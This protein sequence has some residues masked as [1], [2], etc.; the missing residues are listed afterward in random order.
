MRAEDNERQGA[1]PALAALAVLELALSGHDIPPE[2]LAEILERMGALRERF[3]GV[4]GSAN[5]PA[6]DLSKLAWLAPRDAGELVPTRSGALSIGEGGHVFEAPEQVGKTALILTMLR[7]EFGIDPYDTAQCIPIKAPS[8][9]GRKRMDR[10]E[11]R[12]LSFP[13]L[14]KSLLV[15][16][17]MQNDTYVLHTADM[18]Q[19]CRYAAMFKPQLQLAACNGEVSCISW[20]SKQGKTLAKI[21]DAFRKSDS[22]LQAE[23]VAEGGRVEHFIKLRNNTGLHPQ[24]GE[25]LSALAILTPQ[26]KVYHWAMARV[27]NGRLQCVK[28]VRGDNGSELVKLFKTED[29]EAL[30]GR[31]KNWLHLDKSGMVETEGRM[32]IGLP[33]FLL[34][35]GL[36]FEIA[37]EVLG[38][39]KSSGIESVDREVFMGSKIQTPYWLDDVAPY[40]PAKL[41]G[42]GVGY[43]YEKTGEGT[44]TK[45]I[46]VTSVHSYAVANCCDKKG[47]LRRVR[48]AGIQCIPNKV[49]PEK[50]GAS[51][52][53]YRVD[54]VKCLLPQ[55][56]DENGEIDLLLLDGTHVKA[57][58]VS[59]AVPDR[60][61][62]RAVRA[63]LRHRGI[64]PLP[65]YYCVQAPGEMTKNYA[66]V[67]ADE[68]LPIINEVLA[69]RGKARY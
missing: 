5:K 21:K 27:L 33:A 34:K 7:D 38:N 30:R 12:L 68:A 14:G 51:A 49:I 4:V 13:R 47:L 6:I 28:G 1:Q 67:L 55:I 56:T 50:G 17:A 19:V 42:N 48:E 29:L 54:D 60:D 52:E 18:D 46:A 26:S 24:T 57:L 3:G 31:Y 59:L 37:M 32:L 2:E 44:G 65:S 69:R 10:G 58:L 63:T 53:G 62:F 22:D 35:S 64:E 39:V 40:L 45:K 11:Y 61:D 20:S 36:S 23:V 66:A 15:N 43:I 8:R 9:I 41:G 16:D 25:N